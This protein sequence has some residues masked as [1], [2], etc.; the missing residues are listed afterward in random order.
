VWIVLLKSKVEVSNHHHKF[1]TRI[2]TQHYITPKI[3]RSNIG[4]EFLLTNFYDS[5]G[6]IHIHKSCVETP[7]KNGR[8][9]RKHQHL[10]EVGRDIP[11]QYKLPNTFGSYALSHVFRVYGCLAHAST[12]QSNKTKLQYT[13]ESHFSWITSQVIKACSFLSFH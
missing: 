11:F 1:I 10:L 13:L 6:I 4:L 12:L 7:N 3:V 8:V 5:L 2:Q 9:E